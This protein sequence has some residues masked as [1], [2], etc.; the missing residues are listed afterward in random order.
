[1]LRRILLLLIVAAVG[2]GIWYFCKKP[3]SKEEYLKNLTPQQA[4]EFLEEMNV[5][6]PESYQNVDPDTLGQMAS[7][8][9]A[10]C[11][12]GEYNPYIFSSFEIAQ[13]YKVIDVAVDRYLKTE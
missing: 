11:A 8:A 3:Q 9:I 13:F 2:V 10:S 6:L 5:E 1:M 12:K 7:Q 4:L